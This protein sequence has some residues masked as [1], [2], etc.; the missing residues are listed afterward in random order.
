MLDSL[1]YLFE[2]YWLY[3]AGALV[4]GLVAG[5]FSHSPVKK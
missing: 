1:T 4:I 5:W 2:M 3:L